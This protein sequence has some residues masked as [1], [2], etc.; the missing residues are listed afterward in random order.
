MVW[1]LVFFLL[2]WGALHLV[3]QIQG[4]IAR[5][6][7]RL[8]AAVVCCGFLL[9]RLIV[10]NYGSVG[11]QAGLVVV[12]FVLG[13]MGVPAFL[14][15]R[16]RI[17]KPPVGTWTLGRI[18]KP[19]LFLLSETILI[20]IGVWF[21]GRV[22]EDSDAI[23]ALALCCVGMYLVAGFFREPSQS[24]SATPG[25]GPATPATDGPGRAPWPSASGRG[26]G[27]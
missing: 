27:E 10:N 24:E 4:A 13:A 6:T 5:T 21:A 12:A 22:R 23:G 15:D 16:Q 9:W 25:S 7:P 18:W 1:F 17:F 8:V 19:A 2:V 11:V 3:E 20:V 26:E 14:A